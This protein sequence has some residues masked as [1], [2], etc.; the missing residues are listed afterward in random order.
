MTT[1]RAEDLEAELRECVAD[2]EAGDADAAILMHKMIAIEL[3]EDSMTAYTRDLLAD[4]HLS[5]AKGIPADVAMMTQRVSGRP[6]HAMR[7]REIAAYVRAYRVDW[8]FRHKL[9]IRM[10]DDYHAQRPSDTE[11]F[12]RAAK[13]FGYTSWRSVKNICAARRTRKA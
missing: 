7:Q 6:V 1:T 11:I 12:K 2:V 10:P 8:D 9:G 13:R 4:M 3:R 5:I